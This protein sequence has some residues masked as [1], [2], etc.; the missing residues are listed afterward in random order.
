MAII[1]PHEG[2]ISGLALEAVI[3]AALRIVELE[4]IQPGGVVGVKQQP[5]EYG[6]HLA[7]PG[8][9]LKGNITR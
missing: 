4:A 2:D 6:D 1:Y 8:F 5:A 3:V 9:K 7:R